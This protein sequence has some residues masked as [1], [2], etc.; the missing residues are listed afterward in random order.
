MSQLSLAHNSTNESILTSNLQK[1]SSTPSPSLR[2]E[3]Y[4]SSAPIDFPL[5]Q[6]QQEQNDIDIHPVLDC[7][8]TENNTDNSM[9]DF[10]TNNQNNLTS[11]REVDPTI[12]LGADRGYVD[13]V[14]NT[15][16]AGQVRFQNEQL[17]DYRESRL[18]PAQ[19]SELVH[20]TN[21][22]NDRFL[23][24][25][26]QSNYCTAP[27]S[28]GVYRR[29]PD[30]QCPSDGPGTRRRSAYREG[31]SPGSRRVPDQR[32]GVGLI[33]VKIRPT[34]ILFGLWI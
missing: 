5:Q 21:V 32:R 30:F 9:F 26:P 24:N 10:A 14:S 13:R 19:G 7:M 22:Y 3:K 33:Q 16:Q 4:G 2:R 34:T 20:N 18:R 12:N 8:Q 15:R 6:P 1:L 28:D 25:P 11:R 31:G 29:Q 17:A 27:A 23:V